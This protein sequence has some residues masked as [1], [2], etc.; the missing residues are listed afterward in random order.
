[1]RII[2]HFGNG[3]WRRYLPVETAARYD[4]CAPDRAC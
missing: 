2:E 1:M 3:G 4:Q